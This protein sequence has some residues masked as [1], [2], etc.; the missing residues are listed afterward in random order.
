[1]AAFGNGQTDLM[2]LNTNGNQ[3]FPTLMNPKEGQQDSERVLS[4]RIRL[5]LE[6]KTATP[7]LILTPNPPTNNVFM[8]A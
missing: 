3:W 5:P 6:L 4:A 7:C 8:Y 1:M 2:C